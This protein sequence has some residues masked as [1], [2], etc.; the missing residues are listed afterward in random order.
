MHLFSDASVWVN[1]G[2]DNKITDIKIG[3]L[4]DLNSRGPQTINYQILDTSRIEHEI[5]LFERPFFNVPHIFITLVLE[6]K[7]LSNPMFAYL[8]PDG[9]YWEHLQNRNL[10]AHVSNN[11]THFPQVYID[12]EKDTRTAYSLP[13]YGLH[14]PNRIKFGMNGGACPERGGDYGRYP[15]GNPGGGWPTMLQEISPLCDALSLD[16]KIWANLWNTFWTDLG[17]G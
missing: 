1:V 9:L 4:A 14:E 16:I 10:G 15:W 6:H 3:S 2:V 7:N 8:R 12:N 5:Y 13:V 11:V 17:V